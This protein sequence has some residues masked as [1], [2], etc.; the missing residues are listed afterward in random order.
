MGRIYSQKVADFR[1]VIDTAHKIGVK[2][3][4]MIG[5]FGV[6][7]M[8]GFHPLETA[9]MLQIKPKASVN[10]KSKELSK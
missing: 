9:K 8:L 4:N 10:P 7:A 1:V 2:P 6:Y 3:R 5:A